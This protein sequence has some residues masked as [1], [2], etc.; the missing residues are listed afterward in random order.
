MTPRPHR[1]ARRWAALRARGG[2]HGGG[3]GISLF[4]VLATFAVVIIVGLVVD[5]GAKAAGLRNPV[6]VR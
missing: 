1:M 4:M 3:G 2:E 6:A 5:G